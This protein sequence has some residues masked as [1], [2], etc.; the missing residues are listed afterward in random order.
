MQK[1]RKT[2]VHRWREGFSRPWMVNFYRDE[3][4][5][6][7][8]YFTR[9][10]YYDWVEMYGIELA[11]DRIYSLKIKTVARPVKSLAKRSEASWPTA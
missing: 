8:G 2:W 11:E 6:S 1:L 4:C 9:M 5:S 3:V 7:E 10:Y